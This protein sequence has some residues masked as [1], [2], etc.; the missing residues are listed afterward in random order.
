MSVKASYSSPLSD[1]ESDL[2]GRG[3]SEHLVDLILRVA[4]N[5]LSIDLNRDTRVNNE[6][7]IYHQL[8]KHTH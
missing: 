3:L 7:E 5:K 4:S 2:I 1:G 6:S 8:H